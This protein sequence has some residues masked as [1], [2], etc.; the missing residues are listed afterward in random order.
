MASL[1]HLCMWVSVHRKCLSYFTICVLE[2]CVCVVWVHVFEAFL[3][4]L[5]W[6]GYS[7][8]IS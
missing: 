1:L 7:T 2:F 5:V 6:I 4:M 3:Q 8:H